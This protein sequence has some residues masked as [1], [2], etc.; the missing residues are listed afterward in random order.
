MINR[1]KDHAQLV[2]PLKD[3]SFRLF[4]ALDKSGVHL[5]PKH[6]YTP[7][8]DYHWLRRNSAS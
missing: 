2:I 1:L 5:L 8:P 7:I 3:F 6:Y 4:M